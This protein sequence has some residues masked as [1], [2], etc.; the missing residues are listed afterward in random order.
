MVIRQ[1]DVFWVNLGEPRGS[2]PAY[3]HPFVII[4]NDVFNASGV[5]TVIGMALTSNLDRAGIPGNVLLPKG[6]ANLPKASVVNA[7]QVF[8]LNKSDLREKIGHVSNEQL[9]KVINGL[10]LV[11]EPKE[12]F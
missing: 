3:R 10:R 1:G 6:E 7:T 5:K 2:E 8:T 9:I 4:Q 11:T 12:I